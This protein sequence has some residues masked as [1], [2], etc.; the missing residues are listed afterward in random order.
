MDIYF[1]VFFFI[2]KIPVYDDDEDVRRCTSG[3]VLVKNRIEFTK[4]H[5]P[6]WRCVGINETF[7]F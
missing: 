5:D 4:R 3:F 6:P 2:K 7:Q 1:S